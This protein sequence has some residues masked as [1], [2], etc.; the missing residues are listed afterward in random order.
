MSR[1][2][3]EQDFRC[4]WP[5]CICKATGIYCKSKPA[6]GPKPKKA[7]ARQTPKA[8]K[9]KIDK[10]M[11]LETD[12]AFYL[13]IWQERPHVDYET[14]LPIYGEFSLLYFHHVLQKKPFPQYRHCA[15]N[16][17]LV[18][19]E[20]HGNADARNWKVCPKIGK[21]TLE[22]EKLHEDGKLTV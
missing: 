19:W 13:H 14:G 10:G 11:L 12:G 21:L 2:N 16:I 5:R 8:K 4:T 20:T 9:K 15:W 1:S 17:V 3:Q 7:I 22:L 18:S 6:T